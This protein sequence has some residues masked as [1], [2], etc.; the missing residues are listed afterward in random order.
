MYTAAPRGGGGGYF[1]NFYVCLLGMCRARDPHFQPWISVPE[2]IIFTNFQKI[3]SGASPFYIFWRILPETII[4]KIFFKFNPFIASHGRLSP[5]AAP[6]AS[7]T[8]PGSSGESHFHAKN[9]SSSF[10]SPLFSRST[11]SSF[12]SPC[13]FFT[14]PRH[15]YLP[16]IWGE[17]PPPPR[18]LRIIPSDFTKIGV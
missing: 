5:N 12:R 7:Q 9:G 17:Y 10:R 15:I 2:H 6:R 11:G 13:Q 1:H 8:R 14:L 3:I 16:L 4:F 18:T